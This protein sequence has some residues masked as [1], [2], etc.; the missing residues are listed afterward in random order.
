[1]ANIE[2]FSQA[3]Q[4][5]LSTGSERVV[6]RLA[7]G[8]FDSLWDFEL[9][10]F[11]EKISLQEG[12]LSGGV[13]SLFSTRASLMPHQV[14][15]AHWALHNPFTKG[16]ILADEVGL[17]K[18]IEAAII[19]KELICRGRARRILIL[20]PAKLVSQWR[21]ELLEKINEDFLILNS[22]E[23]RRVEAA[24]LNPWASTNRVIASLDYA[25]AKGD[26]G[27]RARLEQINERPWDLLI[28]D[29]AHALKDPGSGNH[30]FI[31]G[32]NREHTLFLTG[33]PIRNYAWDLFHV[34]NII[35]RREEKPLGT[36]Y[37]F[38]KTF[39]Q[40][41]RGLRVKNVPE[42][43]ERVE[44]F[45]IR[46]TKSKVPEIRQVRRIGRTFHFEMHGPEREFHARAE[47][48]IY[49]LY[50]DGRA[51]QGEFYKVLLASGLRKLLAS[52][53]QAVVPTLEARLAR[54]RAVDSAGLVEEAT[55]PDTFFASAGSENPVE[56]ASEDLEAQSARLKKRRTPEQQRAR[57]REE[58]DELHEILADAARVTANAKLD[59]LIAALRSPSLRP[60]E[61][62]LVFTE[63][64]RTMDLLVGALRVAGF[65]VDGFHGGLPRFRPGAR[66]PHRSPDGAGRT[67]EDVFV[68][69]RDSSEA[70]TQVVVATEAA[71]EGL[72]LQ[73]CRVV[74]NYDLPWNPQ[75]I[76]QRI[77][78]VHRIGQKD[79]VI[80]V[81]LAVQGSMDD[82]ILRLLQ[83][84]IRLFDTILGESELILG[85]IDEAQIYNFEEQLMDIAARAR[86]PEHIRAEMERFRTEMDEVLRE[87]QEQMRL[88]L[89]DFDDRVTDHL[90]HTPE[91]PS[92]IQLA[93]KRKNGDVEA[94]VRRYLHKH[95]AELEASTR[96]GV[97]VF[98]TPAA[99]R[100][101]YPEL[102]TE[103]RATFQQEIANEA[104]D[105]DYIAHGHPFLMA[106]VEE[107]RSIGETARLVLRYSDSDRRLHG[108]DHLPGRCGLW[109]NFK[110]TFSSFDTE[111]CLFP[112]FVGDGLE[113][114]DVFS[115][116][117][118][119]Y[120]LIEAP[121]TP[122]VPVAEVARGSERAR[123]QLTSEKLTQLRTLN[124]QVFEEEAARIDTFFED[125]LLEFEDEEQSLMRRMEQVQKQRRTAKTFDE[126][127][128][129][130]EEYEQLK[131]RYFT[132]QRENFR[133][134]EEEGQRR[135]RK[136]STLAGQKEPQ[137]R[138]E[139]INA[140]LV[141]IK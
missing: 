79:D 48:Y 130:R 67:R 18:T 27:R 104:I 10:T 109:C 138:V 33:T 62:V 28:V 40:D 87:R 114:S 108:F 2:L 139:L 92:D 105:A 37:S 127:K 58:V 65:R 80:V 111:E 4:T 25:R 98:T 23:A 99:L 131:E 26:D 34:S 8:E 101:R 12:R 61:K 115:F 11:A 47:D 1:M 89:R 137:V 60:G 77:G 69:F 102:A 112:V 118:L 81:N 133:R 97:Y 74:V 71:A 63:Y 96:P 129:L 39:L 68:R 116:R 45:L 53:R 38:R 9:R 84:K 6:E 21:H 124:D 128:A 125:S 119:Y 19:T 91:V 31:R 57:L 49:S 141:A 78:R 134:R 15:V 50:R 107:C 73:F 100:G 120:P 46:N 3:L 29:E 106:A 20:V 24:G 59:A 64:R 113:F 95:G 117:M 126:R 35:E 82:E 94:F 75:K 30:E 56:E 121:T 90:G 44:K 110:V 136:I 85:A 32:I 7:R 52:S 51:Y 72:N 54:L 36:K 43:I 5:S 123:E 135:D 14:R 13:N 88:Q 55:D 86:S 76:E 42:L 93:V 140:A 17:G 66:T 103:Y 132:V 16:V 22:S 41:G 83:E 122:P 70:G